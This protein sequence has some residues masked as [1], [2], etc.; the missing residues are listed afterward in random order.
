MVATIAFASLSDTTL[1]KKG[2]F[3]KITALY[4][5]MLSKN[6]ARDC[7]PLTGNN[8]LAFLIFKSSNDPHWLYSFSIERDAKN[9][10]YV[11]EVTDAKGHQIARESKI[12]K[13]IEKFK[14]HMGDAHNI[15]SWRKA[16]RATERDL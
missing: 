15:Q 14:Y 6:I 5:E 7:T 9:Q 8:L 16:K 3:N 11:Y 12:D 2:D 13:V 10:R 4:T 1:F